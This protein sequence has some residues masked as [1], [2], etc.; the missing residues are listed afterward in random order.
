LRVYTEVY[1]DDKFVEEA[2]VELTLLVER[3]AREHPNWGFDASAHPCNWTECEE[4]E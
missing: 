4:D 3:L 2:A 1:V